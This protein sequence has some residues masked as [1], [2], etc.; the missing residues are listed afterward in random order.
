MRTTMVPNYDEIA[1][2]ATT[3]LREELGDTADIRTERGYQGRVRVEV[4]SDRLNPLSERQKQEFLWD[5]LRDHLGA[6]ATRITFV[7]GY[8]TNEI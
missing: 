2:K 4:I 8:G 3:A 7:I 5:I 6:D 1:A